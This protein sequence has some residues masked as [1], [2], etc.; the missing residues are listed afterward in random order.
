MQAVEGS[1]G[2]P[3]AGPT[4]EC[5]ICSDDVQEKDMDICDAEFSQHRFCINCIKR[6]YGNT[7][8][9]VGKIY[10]LFKTH[11]CDCA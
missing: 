4:V 10:K 8:H 11:I 2:T 3:A 7:E 5:S 1:V 9:F 6:Y